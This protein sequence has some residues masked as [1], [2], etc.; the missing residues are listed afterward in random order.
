MCQPWKSPK[1]E[2]LEVARVLTLPL[3]ESIGW[4]PLTDG[5]GKMQVF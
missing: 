2:T 5:R 1:K 3:L 4:L